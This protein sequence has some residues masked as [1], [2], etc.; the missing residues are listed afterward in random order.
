LLNIDPKSEK[1]VII[2][3]V[4]CV[5]VLLLLVILLSVFLIRRRAHLRQKLA[6]DVMPKKKKMLDDEESLIRGDGGDNRICQSWFKYL[7]FIKRSTKCDGSAGRHDQQSPA[8]NQDYQ[9]LCRQRMQNK[10]STKSTTSVS[11]SNTTV[12]TPGLVA[13]G[14][15]NSSSAINSTPIRVT[16]SVGSEAVKS[17]DSSRSST[18]SW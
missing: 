16:N 8:S 5:S 3:A 10:G 4:S 18:S 7:P 17:S 9:E 15:M 12:D 14:I 6:E 1:F 13:S 2:T 11:S